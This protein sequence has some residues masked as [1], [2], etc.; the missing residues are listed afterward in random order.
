MLSMSLT[1]RDPSRSLELLVDGRRV[2]KFVVIFL[3]CQTTVHFKKTKIDGTL[4]FLQEWRRLTLT[5]T[6]DRSYFKGIPLGIPYRGILPSSKNPGFF[7]LQVGFAK[8]PKWRIGKISSKFSAQSLIYLLISINLVP[9]SI[10]FI[11]Y[12]LFGAQKTDNFTHSCSS[13]EN[14][15]VRN[16]S[17]FS[18]QFGPTRIF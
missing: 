5:E 3:T 14:H 18:D 2:G 7:I 10:S 13:L 8:E 9:K 12:D 11:I 16:M 6:E 17:P 15:H 4:C 1:V